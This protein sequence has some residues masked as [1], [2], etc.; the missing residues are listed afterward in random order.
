MPDWVA[1]KELKLSYHNGHTYIYRERE[2][3]ITEI[4]FL[5]SNPADCDLNAKRKGT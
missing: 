2:R 3:I 5:N 4:T 1:V